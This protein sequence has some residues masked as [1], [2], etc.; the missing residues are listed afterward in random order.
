MV[1]KYIDIYAAF[2]FIAKVFDTAHFINSLYSW[3]AFNTE[4]VGNIIG[5]AL[6]EL[7]NHINLNR[8]HL[9]GEI[10]ITIF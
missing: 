3:S 2:H 8:I 6:V 4:A 9:I 5:H 1:M 10:L 7:V